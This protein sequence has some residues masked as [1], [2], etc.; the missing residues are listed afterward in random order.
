[1]VK[2]VGCISPILIVMVPFVSSALLYP[3]RVV[4][5]RRS[6]FPYRIL[7]LGER[8]AGAVPQHMFA[9]SYLLRRLNIELS[10]IY[11]RL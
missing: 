10:S 2:V 6:L 8:V 1:M 11:R 3:G 7:H 4:F 9:N 5:V